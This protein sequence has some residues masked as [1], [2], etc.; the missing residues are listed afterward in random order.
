[1]LSDCE[2]CAKRMLPGDEDKLLCAAA[3]TSYL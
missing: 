2:S 1:M 3:G